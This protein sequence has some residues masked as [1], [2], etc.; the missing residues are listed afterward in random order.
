MIDEKQFEQMSFGEVMRQ[1]GR[2][3]SETLAEQGAVWAVYGGLF[4]LAF[5]GTM[6]VRTS[7]VFSVVAV[8]SMIL[9]ILMLPGISHALGGMMAPAA[10]RLLCDGEPSYGVAWHRLLPVLWASTL[11]GVLFALMAQLFV[12]PAYLVLFILWPWSMVAACEPEA[13]A[14]KR[15]QQVSSGAV[16]KV[17]VWYM[18]LFLIVGVPM[19][20]GTIL[21]AM[22]YT[23][24]ANTAASDAFLLLFLLLIGIAVVAVSGLQ[25]A[26]WATLYALRVRD[27]RATQG[28]ELLQVFD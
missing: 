25:G 8:P 19:F 16:G 7:M 24:A 26:F 17:L 1:T 11:M 2:V 23:S 9:F 27:E 4:V 12:V 18:G 5:G 10:V 28:Q 3:W 13:K 6:M 21:Y 15:A 22:A 20:I 14:F